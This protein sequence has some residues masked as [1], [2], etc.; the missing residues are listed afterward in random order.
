MKASGCFVSVLVI[1][2][3]LMV[4]G[5]KGQPT[6]APV[7]ELGWHEQ[8]FDHARLQIEQE[9]GAGSLDGYET[10][11]WSQYSLRRAYAKLCDYIVYRNS[12]DLQEAA[13]LG[14]EVLDADPSNPMANFVMGRIHLQTG[15]FGYAARHLM[16]VPE[17]AA[18]YVQ[19]QL[20]TAS[21]L[22]RM[23]TVK[24]FAV[25]GGNE[26]PELAD[27]QYYLLDAGRA[28]TDADRRQW[29]N[30]AE[31]TLAR[32]AKQRPND[33][34]IDYLRGLIGQQRGT[35]EGKPQAWEKEVKANLG[36]YLNAVVV[37]G[38]NWRQVEYAAIVCGGSEMKDVPE[39]IRESIVRWRNINS[40]LNQVRRAT[41]FARANAPVLIADVCVRA[42]EQAGTFRELVMDGEE[43]FSCIFSSNKADDVSRAFDQAVAGQRNISASV[44]S[45]AEKNGVKLVGQIARGATSR[46]VSEIRLPMWNAQSSQSYVDTKMVDALA[47]MQLTVTPTW[48]V[49]P[50][51]E[52]GVMTLECNANAQLTSV[53]SAI[54]LLRTL[55][56][57]IGDLPS[58]YSLVTITRSGNDVAVHAVLRIYFRHQAT[59]RPYVIQ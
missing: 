43:R 7:A 37:D 44:E 50:S 53:A 27:P 16:A 54:D 15:A 57:A 9:A 24:V 22:A 38:L 40:T 18:F 28:V 10:A 42:Q 31:A 25:Q 52:I 19:S 29:L 56:G 46:P 32:V 51:H 55:K 33:S 13:R 1:V 8:S 5:A 59:T 23:A 14:R 30:Q 58:G 34:E 36:K 17:E 49:V 47:K 35:L 3:L 12:E 4:T 41:V 26:V 11:L 6:S 48:K 20:S 21:A 45:G 39:R 2:F